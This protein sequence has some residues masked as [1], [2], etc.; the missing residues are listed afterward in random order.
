LRINVIGLFVLCN[1]KY[2]FFRVLK[3]LLYALLLDDGRFA[4]F[5]NSN[6][7]LFKG[8]VRKMYRH[9]KEMENR[10]QKRMSN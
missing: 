1:I 7:L 4:L 5:K 9:K 3:Q 8:Q 10:E 2:I 6:T